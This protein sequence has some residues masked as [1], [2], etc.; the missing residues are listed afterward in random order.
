MALYEDPLRPGWKPADVVWEIAL[1]EGFPLTSRLEP[2]PKASKTWRMMDAERGQSIVVNLD[3]TL[4][5]EVVKALN[6]TKQTRFIC[7]DVA[8]TDEQA[9]NLALQCDLKTL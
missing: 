9:A 4:K 7:R 2:V 8:L 1:R 5:P 3:D 6:L